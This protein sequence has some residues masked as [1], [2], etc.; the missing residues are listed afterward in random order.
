MVDSMWNLQPWL[1][2]ILLFNK[3]QAKLLIVAISKNV[4]IFQQLKVF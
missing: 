2:K 4:Q 3:W 1:W